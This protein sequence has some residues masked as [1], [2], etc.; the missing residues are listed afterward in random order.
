MTKRAFNDLSIMKAL[1]F[2]SILLCIGC[3]YHEELDEQNNNTETPS[4]YIS[5]DMDMFLNNGTR[6]AGPT[7]DYETSIEHDVMRLHII[8]FNERNKVLGV[9]HS[10]KFTNS[11]LS[12]PY[13][14]D[15]KTKKIF[16]AVNSRGEYDEIIESQMTTY[17][18]FNQPFPFYQPGEEGREDWLLMFSDDVDDNNEGLTTIEPIIPESFSKE[19]IEAAKAKASQRPITIKAERAY[20]KIDLVQVLEDIDPSNVINGTASIIAWRMSTINNTFLPYAQRIGYSLPN[21]YEPAKYRI[22]TNWEALTMQ[23]SN[24]GKSII[25]TAVDAFIWLKNRPESWYSGGPRFISENTMSQEAQNYNN[26]TKMIVMARFTPHGV[27]D[28]N[29]WFRMKGVV[30]SFDE[31]KELYKNPATPQSVKSSIDRFY[32]ELMKHSDKPK[33]NSFADAEYLTISNILLGGYFA[34]TIDP[35]EIEFYPK[36]VCYYTIPIKHD[37]RVEPFGLGRWGVVRNNSYKINI[38]RITKPG[39]PYIPDP[40]DPTIKDPANP[41]PENP[42]PNDEILSGIEAEIT[43]EPWGLWEQETDL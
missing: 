10:S 5:I 40:T 15:S 7:E 2:L 34:A 14:I 11:P 4:A 37:N 35:Y 3:N 18:A 1:L 39:L 43:I 36:S 16:V 13:E 27:N 28:K 42:T 24:D 33:G 9:H 29:T 21:Y 8:T 26:T 12:G 17:N 38:T 22:D 6:D 32:D 41:D 30:Y 25:G 23:R 31:F 20:A 19:D